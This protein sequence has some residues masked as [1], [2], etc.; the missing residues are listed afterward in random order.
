MIDSEFE[1]AGNKAFVILAAYIFGNNVSKS[2]IAM[3]A[4]VT[5]FKTSGGYLVQ[6]EMPNQY[7][8]DSI[9]QPND[10]RVKIVQVP[11]RKVAAY[12]YSGSW[13]QANFEKN[14]KEFKSDLAKD[15]IQTRGEPFFARFNSPY[16]LW[17]LRRNEIWFELEK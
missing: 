9:P 12:R 14:L 10:S 11:Q 13:S 8:L 2:K 1:D 15:K 6:F 16:Q 7:T 5:Q 17:F 4:P 3:M